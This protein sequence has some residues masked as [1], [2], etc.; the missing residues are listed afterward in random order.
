VLLRPLPYRDPARLMY[1]YSSSPERG[2][3]VSPTSPPDFREMRDHNR[4]LTSLSGYFNSASNLSGD[5][6]A[7]RLSGMVVSTEFFDTLGVRPLLGRTFRASEG[8]W[9]S[10]RVVILG[11]SFW[12]A[13]FGGRQDIL[14]SVLRLDGDLCTV[15]GVMPASFYFSGEQQIWAPM[16]FKPGD[17]FDSH[18]NYFLSMVGRLKPGVMRERAGADLNAIMAEIAARQPENKGVGAGLIPFTEQVVGDV[19]R[20]LWVLLAAVGFVLLI[21]CVNLS[22]LLLSRDAARKKELSLIHI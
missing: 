16:A 11:E 17:N 13:R 1:I 20:S 19:R 18:N 5:F 2:F 6:Q 22:S 8:V 12:R 4:T 15:I 14:G 7:E 21:C 10:H 9:G 3:P